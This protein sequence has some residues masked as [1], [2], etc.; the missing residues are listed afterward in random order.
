MELKTTKP[1][2]GLTPRQLQLLRAVAG[3][4]ASRCYSPT[5]GELAG[6]I[7]V[8]RSTVF[9]HI[10]ELRKKD[11]ISACPGKARSLKLTSKAHE[12]L[13]QIAEGNRESLSERPT[14]IALVGRV[15]AGSPIEAIENRE[16]LSLNRYF[17]GGDDIFALEVTGDSMVG[18]DICEGDYVICRRS[19]VANNGQ[20]VV[21]I[22][23]NEDATL[24]R[25]YRENG[26]VRLQAANDD[27][28]P[29]YSDNCRIEAVVV[30]LVRKL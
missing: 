14:G 9:E 11:M 8:S 18:D 30:G 23:D 12:L 26:R 24:K 28:E 19:C 22:V 25:F 29:I 7:G 20:L 10:A 27:F 2:N 21:A 17:G 6:E 3:F 4:K 15:A 5:I 16:Q 13:R 1:T